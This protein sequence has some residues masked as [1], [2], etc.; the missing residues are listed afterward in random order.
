MKKYHLQNTTIKHTAL[1]LMLIS[2]LASCKAQPKQEALISNTD[3][4][5][6]LWEVSGNGLKQNTYLFGTFHLM[7]R[8]DINLSNQLKTAV[9]NS[10]VVYMEMDM[11]DPSVVMGGLLMMNMKDGKKLK[12]LYTEE[13]Y[14]K[15]SVFFKDSLKMSL[16]FVER[17]KPYFLMA[18]LYPKMM[19]C[20]S[21]SG[22]EEVLMRL[23]KTEQKEIKG[24]ETIQFQT[25]VFDSIPYEAQAKEL[26]TGIDSMKSYAKYFD[27]MVQVYKSQQLPAMEALLTRKELGMQDRM[28][29]LL[30]KRN[31]NW[32]QQLKQIMPKQPVFVA[33]GAG[34][35]LGNNGLI[36]LLKK[37]GYKLR[38]LLNK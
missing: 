26:L 14:K 17:S 36:A 20:K 38:P 30:D 13:E 5:S 8:S 24:L 19:P 12:D 37:E 16:G 7:C 29:L 21:V 9:K 11:D 27:T 3:D 4:N 35:L 25:S 34:H 32:V 22:V 23:A 1:M 28:D 33:V 31:K 10:N 6:L 2:F 15:L 18:M